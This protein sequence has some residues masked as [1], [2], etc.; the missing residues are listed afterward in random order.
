MF[1]PIGAE[2]IRANC[3]R[4]YHSTVK[5]VQSIPEILD[6]A[7]FLKLPIPLRL[8]HVNLMCAIENMKTW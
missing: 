7:A 2:K 3:G 8:L 5:H 6:E 1:P 4:I